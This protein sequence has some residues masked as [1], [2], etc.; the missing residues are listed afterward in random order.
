MAATETNVEDDFAPLDIKCTS[1]RCEKNLHCFRPKKPRK[2][3][4][5]NGEGQSHQRLLFEELQHPQSPGQPGGCRSCGI[6]TVDW[7]RIHKR[8]WQ[9]PHTRKRCSNL[10]CGGTLTGTDGLISGH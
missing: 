1:S 7:T 10:R 2:K 5:Q 9:T 8:N 3:A 6:Q 4:S